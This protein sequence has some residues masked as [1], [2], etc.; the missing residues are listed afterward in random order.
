MASPVK[1]P[2]PSRKDR[3]A[4]TR[5][6]VLAAATAEFVANGYHGTPMSAIAARAGVAVQTVYFV[7][8]TKPELFAAALDAAVLGP[9]E[10]P[11]M[12]QHWAAEVAAGTTPALLAVEAFIR[13]SGPIFERAAALSEVASAAAATD[14][15]L[16]EIYQTREGYRI[17]GYRDL[18]RSLDLSDDSD[19]DRALD[20]L[21]TLHSP[22]L[23]LAF[24]DGRGWSHSAVIDWMAG[25]IPPLVL[26]E[27]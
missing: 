23:Y 14:P 22:R 21:V 17:A 2:R 19:P 26:Q 13:G 15:E 25:T 16:A 24:K 18:V 1:T 27:T 9:E 7:F 8:H 11:P 5:R 6:R 10:R 20:L 4:A 12:E 3:A